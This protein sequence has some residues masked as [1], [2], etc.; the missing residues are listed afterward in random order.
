MFLVLLGSSARQ[1][2]VE[3]G[4]SAMPTMLLHLCSD[5]AS[6]YSIEKNPTGLLDHLQGKAADHLPCGVI[7]SLPAFSSLKYCRVAHH[8]GRH[9]ALRLTCPLCIAAIAMMRNM[10]CAGVRLQ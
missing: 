5:V 6:S 10:R 1:C 9:A 7:L 2:T 4:L 8:Q 3:Y